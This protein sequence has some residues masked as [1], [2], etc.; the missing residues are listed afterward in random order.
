MFHLA[1][2]W[3]NA[4][5]VLATG[6]L[7]PPLFMSRGEL[8]TIGDS[9]HRRAVPFLWRRGQAPYPICQSSQTGAACA[10]P[11]VTTGRASLS[12]RCGLPDRPVQLLTPGPRHGGPL[13]GDARGRLTPWDI[14]GPPPRSTLRACV[15][16]ELD[17][18]GGSALPREGGSSLRFLHPT[19]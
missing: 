4:G 13:P 14:G 15:A 12:L 11:G 19:T 5:P 17:C 1:G 7:P 18:S 2:P 16:F 8:G 3:S 10:L 6:R 9:V